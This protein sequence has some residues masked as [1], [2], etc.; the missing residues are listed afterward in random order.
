MRFVTHH[1]FPVVFAILA[2]TVAAQAQTS[3]QLHAKY[4]EPQMVELK[5][6][7]PVLER[8][9]VR[10][11][12]Q[13]TIRYTSSGEPCEAVLKPV[14][15]STSKTGR[16]AHAPEGD[17]MSTAEVIKLINEIL[18]TE[19]RGKKINEG[20]MNGGDPAM[21]LHHPGCAG[22]YFVY[23]E[24]AAVTASSWCWGGTF[25]AT[26]RWG[27]TSCPGENIKFKSK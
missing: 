16:P 12:I 7:R 4:G 9:L 8:F 3:S 21:K 23:F 27:K 17:Y 14:P 6:D 22:G 25:S 15:N 24:N 19:I 1:T 18:P 11:D 13:M 20:F 26:I 10:P 5:N 2:I